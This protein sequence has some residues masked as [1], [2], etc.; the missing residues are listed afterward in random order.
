MNYRMLSFEWPG[1][2]PTQHFKGTQLF[3]VEYLRNDTKYR[4]NYNG[5]LCDPS[6][7]AL[8]NDFE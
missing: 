2:I 3:D 6:N 8:S 1:M 7:G 5:I 4:H